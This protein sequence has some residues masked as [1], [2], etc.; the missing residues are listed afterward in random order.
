MRNTPLLA[1]TQARRLLTWNR[2]WG[3]GGGHEGSRAQTQQIPAQ[4]AYNRPGLSGNAAAW[5]R[6]VQLER[7]ANGN[8]NEAKQSASWA[9]L[10]NRSQSSC[11]HTLLDYKSRSM[12]REFHMDSCFQ[13][14]NKC[15]GSHSLVIHLNSFPQ[16]LSV[17][18]RIAHQGLKQDWRQTQVGGT[19]CYE[20][21][22]YCV[23]M[24]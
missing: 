12:S 2:P 8:G 22:S 9:R 5:R 13:W 4:S 24:T 15:F 14:E 19:A 18:H 23:L 3:D 16:S 1:T 11:T 20:N 10:T 17:M 21:K 7:Q 6:S